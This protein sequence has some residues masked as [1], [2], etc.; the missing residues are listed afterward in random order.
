MEGSAMDDEW[1]RSEC[2][3]ALERCEELASAWGLSVAVR[4]CRKVAELQLRGCLGMF[5]SAVDAARFGIPSGYGL[6]VV[7]VEQLLALS[8][9][10]SRVVSVAAHEVAHGVQD[11]LET[12]CFGP[13]IETP[14]DF[15][16]TIW[17]PGRLVEVGRPAWLGHGPEFLRAAAHVVYRLRCS[18]LTPEERWCFPPDVYRVSSLE[19]YTQALQGEPERLAGVPIVAALQTEAPAGFRALWREDVERAAAKI[20]TSGSSRRCFLIGHYSE[21]PSSKHS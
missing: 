12:I 7:D 5:V 16:P 1:L 3:R 17:T 8:D 6:A 19:R 14:E 13:A 18:G 2:H 9:P 15:E 21:E 10:V 20:L 11:A 4:D